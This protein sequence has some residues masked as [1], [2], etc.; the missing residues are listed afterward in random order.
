MRMVPEVRVSPSVQAL[1]S[2]KTIPYTSSTVQHNK[3]ITM[4][5]IVEKQN[6]LAVHAIC[7][8]L[9]RAQHWLNVNAPEYVARGY[10]SDKT[11]TADSFVIVESSK[12]QQ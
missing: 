12:A 7:D 1:D 3:G 8:T 9:A 2:C 6:P 10:F 5:K 11:L 4:Y